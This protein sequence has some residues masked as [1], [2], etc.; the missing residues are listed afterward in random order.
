MYNDY[1]NKQAQEI[2]QAQ[3]KSS[4]LRRLSSLFVMA[5]LLALVAT[6]A[7]AFFVRFPP[8]ASP[9]QETTLATAFRQLTKNTAWTQTDVIAVDFDTYHGQ[10][11]AKGGEH[12]FLSSVEILEPTR[13][14]D[15][16]REGL[17]RTTGRGKGHLFK[18]D[19]DGRLLAQIELGEGVIYHPGGID[20]DG[21]YLWVP[22]AEYRPNSR[23]IVY[24][25]DPESMQ[26]VEIFRFDDHLGGLVYSP[27]DGTLY[28][29][30]WG[31]RRFYTWHLNDARHPAEPGAS[32]EP[33]RTL[34]PAHYIDYQDC[35]Y[36]GAGEAL[37]A[38][39]NHYRQPTGSRAFALGGL[40]L[41]D[42]RQGR[43]LHQI[44]VPLWTEDGLVLTRNPVVLE[45]TEQGLR[46]YFM[47]EDN[48]SRLFI[49]DVSLHQ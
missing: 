47:P 18:M 15:T 49:F 22:V 42:L 3:A 28:G 31:S 7:T 25:V 35:Q 27:D 32:P 11:F 9:A 48:Q 16:P 24:R 41:I 13:R 1:P 44:P 39:L 30:S 17:D 5:V 14:Y 29:V 21:T 34:N 45:A 6:M 46:G 38:G 26:A 4:S 10:G 40:E 36:V 20:F 23:S 8:Q 19:L 33:L 37:C 12:L 43:P 2:H